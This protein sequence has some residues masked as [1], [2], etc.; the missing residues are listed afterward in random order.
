MKT[1]ATY[2]ESDGSVVTFESNSSLRS[3]AD[4]ARRYAKEGYP[5]RYVVFTN[6][7]NKV[8][9]SKKKVLELET[10][11][12]LFMS[13]IL[14]P[15]I[16][17]SQASLLN[18][19]A[20]AAMASALEEHTEK[21]IG[22]GWISDIYCEGSKIGKVTIEGKLDDYT[23]YEYIIVNFECKISKENFPYKLDD[24]VSTVFDND[25]TSVNMYIARNVLTKFFKMYP[26]LK[27][28]TKFMAEYTKRFALRGKKVK[29]KVGEKWKT[30]KVLSVDTKTCALIIDNG[31]SPDIHVTSPGL[32]ITP[33]RVNKK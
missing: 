1:V 4:V 16:F 17:P 13:C 30:H 15:S 31:K 2:R 22:I 27:N 26:N 25:N 14:R 28:P 8:R 10:E 23:T 9:T 33:K 3:T 21:K 20:A 7:R 29:Y 32:I 11:R 19:M 6:R 12:G 5:D 18:P 24:M